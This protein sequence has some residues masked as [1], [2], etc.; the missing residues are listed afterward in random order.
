MHMVCAACGSE[1][2]IGRETLFKPCP[3]KLVSYCSPEC[4]RAD[5]KTHKRECSAARKGEN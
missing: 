4:Q 2:E 5:W 3:C 1:W